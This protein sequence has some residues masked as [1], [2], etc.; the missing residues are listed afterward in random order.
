MHLNTFVDDKVTSQYQKFGYIGPDSLAKAFKWQ[1][2][3]E[4]DFWGLLTLL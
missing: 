4:Y 2:Q 1:Y 3:I